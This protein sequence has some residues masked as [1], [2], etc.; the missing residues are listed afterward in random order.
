MSIPLL[1]QFGICDIAQATSQHGLFMYD[2][3]I[4]LDYPFPV[5]A[6]ISEESYVE[7]MTPLD[8]IFALESILTHNRFSLEKRETQSSLH[9]LVRHLP[10]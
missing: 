5:H 6:M 8:N 2:N 4:A 9:S 7:R 1:Y 10:T 3:Q